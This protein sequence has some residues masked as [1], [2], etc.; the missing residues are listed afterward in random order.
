MKRFSSPAHY[1]IAGT[2]LELIDVLKSKAIY[3]SDPWEFF[4]WASGMQYLFRYMV[5]GEPDKDL[6]KEHAYTNW[7]REY[8]QEQA[9]QA[10][11]DQEDHRYD[12]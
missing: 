5:K 8:R 7:L 6:Q 3:F 12:N 9:Q 1:R 11:K 10:R 4:L 2:D